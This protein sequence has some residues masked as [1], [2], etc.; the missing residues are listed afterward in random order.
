MRAQGYG[1]GT[2][3]P[4][5]FGFQPACCLRIWHL[6]NPYALSAARRRLQNSR[7]GHAV[8]A[9]KCTLLTHTKSPSGEILVGV[10]WIVLRQEEDDLWMYRL[11]PLARLPAGKAAHNIIASDC[12]TW[13]QRRNSTTCAAS[14]LEGCLAGSSQPPLPKMVW[15]ASFYSSCG[16][17]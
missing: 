13:K 17:V 15:I 12:A 1:L 4:E 7:R 3:V 6:S 5:G 16:L 14:M 11:R 8:Q 9:A 10:P 2:G